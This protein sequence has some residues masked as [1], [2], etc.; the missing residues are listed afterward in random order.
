MPSDKLTSPNDP[1]K[2]RTLDCIETRAG[3]ILFQED[4]EA[5]TKVPSRNPIVRLYNQLN[6]GITLAAG[7]SIWNTTGVKSLNST[8]DFNISSK[9]VF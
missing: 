6:E 7:A 8:G 3:G 2:L 1:N 9:A 5:D 4:K